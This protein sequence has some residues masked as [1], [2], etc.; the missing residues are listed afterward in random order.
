MKTLARR[1]SR[2]AT[3]L[4]GAAIAVTAFSLGR[5]THR[6]PPEPRAPEP[7]PSASASERPSVRS[8]SALLIPAFTPATPASAEGTPL[9][10]A[11]AEARASRAN[12]LVTRL[13]ARLDA[14]PT[15]TGDSELRVNT[16]SDY[17]TAMSDVVRQLDPGMFEAMAGEFTRRLCD[18]ELGE[19]QTITMAYLG[20]S[21][22]EAV[23]GRGLE[24][25]FSGAAGREDIRLWTMLDAWRQSGQERTP[26]IAALEK[27]ARD[28]RT[29]RRFLPIEVERR[30]RQ[31]Q[32]AS[33]P[34]L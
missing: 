31:A 30:Q 14:I 23:T 34:S 8:R 4:G 2:F 19:D 16:M 29:R 18:Q 5:V 32:S 28:P 26:A 13:F 25:F 33:L 22:P 6:P 10:S 11:S 3:V 1:P 27:S 21:M 20:Q 9:P 15:N 17:L 24:C 12:Y 7:T